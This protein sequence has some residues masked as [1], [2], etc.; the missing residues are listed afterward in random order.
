M[1]DAGRKS[2]SR[3]KGYEYLTIGRLV[4]R[5]LAEDKKKSVITV[6]AMAATGVF[7]MIVATVLS[8]ADPRE[9][10]DGSVLGQ[11][12]IF[13]DIEENNKEHPERKWSEVQ[14]DNPLNEALMKQVEAIPGVEG[15]SRENRLWRRT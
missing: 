8:C 14:K 1:Q 15:V 10:A 13:S 7:L 12:E 4:C 3:R 5:N 6:L 2:K 11:Y 9:S